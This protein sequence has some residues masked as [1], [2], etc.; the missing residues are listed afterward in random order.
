MAMKRATI[1][2]I[3]CT[4]TL[5]A[6]W[7][8]PVLGAPRF[9]DRDLALRL[10][11]VLDK[12]VFENKLI[13]STFIRKIGADKYVVKIVLDNGSEQ[14]WEMDQLREWTRNE[15]LVLRKNKA[16]IFP[17]KE[18]NEFSVFDKNEFV[19]H[20][21]RSNVYVKLHHPPDILAGQTISFQIYRFNLV[22][23]LNVSA[24]R[25]RN[26]YPHQYVLDLQNGQREYLSY[27]EAQAVVHRGALIDAAGGNS[28]V[29]R[30]PYRLRSIHKRKLTKLS[31]GGKAEFGIDLIFNRPVELADVHFPFQLYEKSSRAGSRGFS[32]FDFVFE[33]TVPNAVLG[34][35]VNR[36]GSLEYLR[37]IHAVSDPVH[38]R[39][40]LVRAAINP[41]VFTSPPDIVV[42]ENSV[43][44]TFSKV[45]DQSVLDRKSIQSEETRRRQARLLADTVTDEEIRRVNEYL[46]A[47][48]TG[49]DQLRNA[50]HASQFGEAFEDYLAAM[51]NFTAAAANASTD[52]ELQ[53][54][55]RQRNALLVNIPLMVLEHAEMAVKLSPIPDPDGLTRLIDISSEMTRDDQVI[56]A[57]KALKQKVAA[58]GN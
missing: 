37:D 50:R 14:E 30:T 51:T 58:G 20:A 16:L 46:L 36:I 35:R 44:I 13:S 24:T 56:K 47:M 2:Q 1:I 7:C 9:A 18:N 28:V 52:R 49:R 17:T 6:F 33:V 54:S 41:V 3:I 5:L 4:L 12:G 8:S 34:R 25:D 15:T 40:V 10:A 39:R 19:Q 32:E 53:D 21:L 29:E 31:D 26:G 22:K 57:L 45:I 23:L 55:M 43:M 42:S 38:P 27:R 48:E 11:K